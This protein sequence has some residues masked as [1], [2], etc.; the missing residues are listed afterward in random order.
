MPFGKPA[1]ARGSASNFA[2]QSTQVFGPRVP[3]RAISLWRLNLKSETANS[4][5]GSNVAPSWTGLPVMRWPVC[6]RMRAM[7]F[8]FP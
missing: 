4:P 1:Y 7:V 6:L 2:V 3:K 8:K 5:P